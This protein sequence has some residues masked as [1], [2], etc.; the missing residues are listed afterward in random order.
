MR[1]PSERSRLSVPRYRVEHRSPDVSA[2]IVGFAD[3][4]LIA[5]GQLASAATRLTFRHAPG[6]AIVIN[7][8]TEPVVLRRSL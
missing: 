8:E 5:R 4:M 2:L 6:E 7:Q 3:T 1:A